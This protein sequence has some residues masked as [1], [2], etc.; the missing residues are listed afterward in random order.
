[1]VSDELATFYFFYNLS[2]GYM[3][4]SFVIA[5]S[6]AYFCFVNSVFVCYISQ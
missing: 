5:L 6:D 3:S 4:I 1:M 2:N